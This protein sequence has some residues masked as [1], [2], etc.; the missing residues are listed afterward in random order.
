MRTK[1][2][3]KEIKKKI[4]LYKDL[5]K[6]DEKY[7]NN[8]IEGLRIALRILETPDDEETSIIDTLSDNKKED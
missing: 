8:Q 7:W 4:D 1:N 5:Q 6:A 3:I 2:A